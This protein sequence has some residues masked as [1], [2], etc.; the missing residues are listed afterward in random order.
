MKN[1]HARGELCYDQLT[2][3]GELG[4]VRPIMRLK[5]LS[6]IACATCGALTAVGQGSST[7]KTVSISLDDALRRAL[8][9]N[10]DIRLGY[11]TPQTARLNLEGIYGDYDPVFRASATH[12]YNQGSGG[13][14]STIGQAIP[15]SETWRQTYQA[16]FSGVLPT[17]TRYDLSSTLGRTDGENRAFV[18][19]IFNTAVEYQSAVNV[20]LT[21]PLLKNFWIDGTR[22]NAG[23]AKIEIKRADLDLQYSIMGVVNSTTLAYYDLIESRDQVK[24]REMALQLKEQFLSETKK[25]VA[26]GTLASLDEKQAES[27]A[28]SARAALIQAR[29]DAEQAENRLKGLIASDF[30][31]IQ[32]T[33]LEPSEKLLAMSQQINVVESWR[34]GLEQ[35]PDFLSR[36]HLIEEEKIQLKYTRNQLYPALDLQAT[37]GRAGLAETAYHS[38]DTIGD[39]RF[40]HYGGGITLTVPLSRRTERT[41]HKIQKIRVEEALLR[42]KAAE[43]EI[44]RG[45]DN[46]A[47]IVRSS[48]ATIESTREAV[49][50]AEAALEAEQKK[51][52]NGKSTNFQVLELQDKLTQA[53]AAAIRALTDYNKALQ[54]FYYAEGTTL[55]RNKINIEM[56]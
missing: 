16:G 54:N 49:V 38:Y 22:L 9:Q 8:Q 25:K 53:R 52:E 18:T 44:I 5:F 29:S 23:I 41:A 47:K 56:K 48:F 1:P 55:Q 30:A 17:G 31:S 36:K 14:N 7:P 40:P 21:Q 27:E 19:N 42:L 50:F 34:T 43:E 33:T 24:V 6:W 32:S 26:A 15:G 13:F 35:R 3:R 45:I 37:Y 39:N 4:N 46:A 20:T 10:F 2:T 11:F 12:N 51:L 28:A